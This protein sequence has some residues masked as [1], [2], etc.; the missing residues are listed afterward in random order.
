MLQDTVVKH[1]VLP[2]ESHVI[3]ELEAAAVNIAT[4]RLS[5]AA[6]V[7]QAVPAVAGAGALAAGWGVA[8]G[9]TD[10][11]LAADRAAL[12]ALT[13][14]GQAARLIWSFRRTKG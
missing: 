12:W 11:G 10:R 4:L 9:L 1:H 14:R 6:V 5:T 3:P 7:L 2:A 8:G 13:V